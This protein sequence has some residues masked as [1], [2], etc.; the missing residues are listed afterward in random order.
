MREL[1]KNISLLYPGASPE[2]ILVTTGAAQA[3]FNSIWAL[4]EPGDEIAVMIWVCNPNNPT[5][6]ILSREK[7]DAIVDVAD[8]VGAWLL[9]DEVYA[10]SERTTDEVTAAFWGQYDRVLSVGSMSKPYAHPGL[11]I[12][13]VVAPPETVEQLWARQDYTT[14]ASTM[15]GNKLAAHALA[16]AVRTRI[17]ASTRDHVRNGYRE[18][19]SW[20]ENFEGLLTWVPLRRPLSLLFDTVSTLTQLR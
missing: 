15:L 3:S 2:N 11:R 8:R 6:H 7:R 19:E 10:G 18:F 5:G 13:W 1:N 12:G 9:A 17:I 20:A 4:V 16:P 14:I